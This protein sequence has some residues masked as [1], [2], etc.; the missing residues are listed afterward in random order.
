MTAH[1]SSFICPFFYILILHYNTS[2]SWLVA[3]IY[4]ISS[5][6][7][8]YFEIYFFQE[9]HACNSWQISGRSLH[10]ATECVFSSHLFLSGYRYFD[11]F[12]TCSHL[13][14]QRGKA[15]AGLRLHLRSLWR[16]RN[17]DWRSAQGIKKGKKKIKVAS[18]PVGSQFLCLHIPRFFFFFVACQKLF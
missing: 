10:K 5:V 16:D 8:I 11:L 15:G 4:E 3:N 2:P 7:Y 6:N 1:L 17:S 9:K 14:S 18:L 13:K 12:V